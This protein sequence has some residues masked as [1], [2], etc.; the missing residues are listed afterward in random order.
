MPAVFD[1]AWDFGGTDNAPG[2][3]AT[4]IT[5]LRF[6]AEDT[7]DHDLLPPIILPSGA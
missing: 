7:N 4:A 2:T 6:N 1:V 5:N 3:D